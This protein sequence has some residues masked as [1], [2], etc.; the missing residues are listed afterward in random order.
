MKQTITFQ[1]LEGTTL[2]LVSAFMYAHL[3]FSLAVFILTLFL[4]DIWMVGYLINNKIGAY[5]YNI[6]HSLS[7]PVIIG[8]VGTYLDTRSVIAVSL[9]WTAHIG[10]DRAFGY[11]LKHESGFKHTHLGSIGKSKRIP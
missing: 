3:D 10:I 6:G 2:F 1:R 11:G 8:V 7:L 5:V 9:I 4:V